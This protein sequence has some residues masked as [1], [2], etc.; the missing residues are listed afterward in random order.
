M[1]YEQTLSRLS[2]LHGI[3]SKEMQQ[4]QPMME[5]EELPVLNAPVIRQGEPCAQL[6]FLVEGRLMQEYQSPDGLYRAQRI[7]DAPCAIEPETIYSLNGVYRYAYQTMSDC[8]FVSIRRGDVTAQLM[9]LEAFRINYINTLSLHIGR[10]QHQLQ[11]E[12]Y[13]TAEEKFRHF[14]A[15]I[16][17]GTSG[18][19]S[20]TIRME[21]L[22]RYIGETRLTVSYMLRRMQ[23][24]GQL[25]QSRG[26]IT[27]TKQRK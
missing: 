24:D 18:P 23:A 8:Q 11:P 15:S 14:V 16:F 10:I 1:H 21:D 13:Q 5:V 19:T 12:Q 25:T 20:L 7:V 6:R 17:P 27:F 9:R 26:R 3:S 22:A 2:L 4:L